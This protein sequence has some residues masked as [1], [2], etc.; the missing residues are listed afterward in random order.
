MNS[1]LVNAD[2]FGL[3]P[4]INRGIADCVGAGNVSSISVCPSG[5]SQDWAALGEIQKK[6]VGV[7]VQ[8]TLVDE[9]WLTDGRVI[10]GWQSLLAQ[11]IGG[12]GKFIVAVEQEAQR[13]IELCRKNGIRL[14]HLDSHQHVHALPGLWQICL[15]LAKEHGIGRV[16]VPV[17]ARWSLIRRSPA[18]I[19]LQLLGRWRMRSTNPALPCIGLAWSGRNTVAIFEAELEKA[20]GMDV[21]LITHPGVTTPALTARFAAWGY[22]WSSERDMLVTAGFREIVARH[23]YKLSGC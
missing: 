10:S 7:G 12:G 22:D 5:T 6:G 1:L 3:H 14:T 20:R 8:I 16:R 17:A 13:Q 9:P 2:D 21:E 4:D 19:V 23:G 15:R 18:G 11:W